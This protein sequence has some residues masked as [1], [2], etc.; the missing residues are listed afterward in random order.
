MISI[1]LLF[2][3]GLYLAIHA[4]RYYTLKEWGM[5]GIRPLFRFVVR[6]KYNNWYAMIKRII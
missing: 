2:T 5:S 3:R 6:S 1:T 4:I